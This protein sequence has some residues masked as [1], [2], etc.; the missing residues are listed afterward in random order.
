MP[1]TA[2]GKIYKPTLRQDA[3]RRAFEAE[4]K[5][6]VEAGT[7]ITVTVENHEVHGTVA[8]VRASN[9]PEGHQGDTV[10][11]KI[12]QALGRYPVKAEV[13]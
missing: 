9:V 13:R 12:L 5:P 4:L 2:V 1:V 10:R 8:S 11:G 7:G 3:S 6:I